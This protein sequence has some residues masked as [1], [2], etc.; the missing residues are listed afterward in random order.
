ML[1]ESP[2]ARVLAVGPDRVLKLAPPGQGVA[3]EIAALGAMQG[4][5]AARL[6]R[7]DA[8]EG[9]L[10]L[11]RATPGTP[12]LDLAR[13]DDDAATRIAAG[14]VAA[15]PCPPPDGA[16][17]AEAAGWGRA[18]AAGAGVLATAMLDRAA[19]L[20]RDLAADAPPLA[21]LH[22][23]LHHRNILREG[24]G[25]V[26][27]DP[28]G[29]LGEPAA[30]AACLLRNPA[31]PALLARAPR[32]AAIIA[33]VAGLDPRRVL[34]WGYA[35]AVIAACWAVEDGADPAPWLAAEAALRP[36]IRHPPPPRRP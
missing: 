29:L 24:D 25:W 33:E 18:L 32:R 15:L 28:K 12:L 6:L 35:G 20:L 34:A 8:A 3:A 13:Q 17:F 36:S 4:R 2:A 31:D 30:E 14:L 9:A 11:A 5:G 10:L 1:A 7:E 26:A 22:G 21:L 16:L 23:D 19:G 27:V